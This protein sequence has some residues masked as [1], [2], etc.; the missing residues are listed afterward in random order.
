MDFV[1]ISN[2]KSLNCWL[3]VL[4]TLLIVGGTGILITSGCGGPEIRYHNWSIKTTSDPP[5]AKIYKAPNSEGEFVAFYGGKKTPIKDSGQISNYSHSY[6]HWSEG[7]YQAKL[8]DYKDSEIICTSAGSHLVLHFNLEL[9]PERPFPPKVVYPNPTDLAIT[10][11]NLDANKVG[12]DQI[13]KDKKIAILPFKEPEGSGAGSLVADSIILN[14]Q[15]RGYDVVDRDQLEQLMREQGLMASG[16]TRLSDLEISKRLGKL[17][18]ADYFIYGAIT[19]YSSSTENIRLSP[20]ISAAEKVRY[21][22][23]YREYTRYYRSIRRRPP[24]Y[25]KAFQEWELQ[26]AASGKSSLISISKVGVTSKIVDIQNSRI[27]WIGIANLS[28]KR[29]QAGMKRIVEGMVNNF[30]R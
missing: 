16:K 23:Q 30:A 14:L 21:E 7:C 9:L 22:R 4:F 15:K 1:K 5:Q 13:S 29:L 3:M 11:L 27:V 26:Y 18:Q 12:L 28:D 24:E 8:D 25:V 10:P 20:T 6:D 19:E 17:V 2:L